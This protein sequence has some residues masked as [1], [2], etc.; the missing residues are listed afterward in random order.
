L[1]CQCLLLDWRSRTYG[2]GDA[3]NININVRSDVVFDGVGVR[4]ASGAFTSVENTG[5]GNAGSIHINSQTLKVKNGA[6]LSSSSTGKGAAGNL[7]ILSNLIRLDNKAGIIS[8]TKGGRGNIN[9]NASNL[10]LRQQSNI[11]TNATGDSNIGGN[12]II[13]TDNL[14]AIPQENSKISANSSNF[15]GGNVAISTNSL[16]GLQLQNTSTNISGITATGADTQL[17]GTVEINRPD[18]DPT[19]GLNKLSVAL[20][21]RSQLIA[22]KCPAIHGDTFIITRRSGLPTSPHESL[23]TH[24]AE[25]VA[26]VKTSYS[27]S[28]QE[29]SSRENY[30]FKESVKKPQIIEASNWVINNK[31][32]VILITSEHPSPRRNFITPKSCPS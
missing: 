29:N 9:L 23:R 30:H 31:G 13:N 14:V 8:D 16:F 26:W 24:Q 25:E 12:I 7:E 20:I 22:Q 19:S 11:T 1:I 18:L 10:I 3:G 6:Q 32:E 27:V 17:D 2:Q 15:R 28:S 4:G 21:D 5:I